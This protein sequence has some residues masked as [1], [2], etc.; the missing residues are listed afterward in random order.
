MHSPTCFHSMTFEI[1]D[2]QVTEKVVFMLNS[3]CPV[4][5]IKIQPQ[6]KEQ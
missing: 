2:G 4:E 1:F 6:A 3:N 5:D